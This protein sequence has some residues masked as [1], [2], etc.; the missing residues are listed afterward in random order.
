MLEGLGGG[1]FAAPVTQDLGLGVLHPSAAHLAFADVTGDARGDL[2]VGGGAVLERSGPGPLDLG[3]VRS[4]GAWGFEDGGTPTD[5]T[6]D[7][8]PDL[9][10][11]GAG[12][13]GV[14]L[15]RSRIVEAA[16]DRAG[17]ERPP[18][19]RQRLPSRPGGAT[20]FGSKSPRA[21]CIGTSRRPLGSR[22]VV[23]PLRPARD[24]TPDHAMSIHRSLRGVNTRAGERSVLTRFERVQKM[25]KDGKLDPSEDTAVGLPK[26]RTKFKVVSGKKAKALAKAKD[27]AGSD[28]E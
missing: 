22:T 27:D 14:D 21:R 15:R 20:L 8:L 4:F 9:L 19:G 26:M 11:R 16:L 24:P 7:G 5:L 1:S 13:S 2:I 28:A 10:L 18:R 23:R 6:A 3:P 12:S 17:D 25:I